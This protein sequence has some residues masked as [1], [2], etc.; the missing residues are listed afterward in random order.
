MKNTIFQMINSGI[1]VEWKSEHRNKFSG[2]RLKSS[3]N[4]GI[5][6]CQAG[7]LQSPAGDRLLTIK[8]TTYTL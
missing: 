3:E 4:D 5:F 7:I 1:F 6:V 2:L 8:F